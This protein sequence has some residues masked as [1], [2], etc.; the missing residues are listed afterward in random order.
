ME[1][2]IDGKLYSFVDAGGLCDPC[3]ECCFWKE[4]TCV[5]KDRDCLKDENENM[6]WYEKEN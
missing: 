4:D 5:T 6:Y 3:P 1:K 2:I